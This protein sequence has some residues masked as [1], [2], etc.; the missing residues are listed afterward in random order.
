MCRGLLMEKDAARNLHGVAES[1]K[2]VELPGLPKKGD[3]GDW[4][5]A[6]GTAEKLAVLV[7]EAPQWEPARSMPEIVITRRFLHDKSNDAIKALENANHPPS[8]F[9]RSGGL[10]RILQMRKITPVLKPLTIFI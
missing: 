1:V 4:I 9:R 5:V 2:L 3:V 6:G 8:L 7:T 10:V